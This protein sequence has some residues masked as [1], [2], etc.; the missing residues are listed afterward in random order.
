MNL[1]QSY[2]NVLILSGV[3]SPARWLSLS[4][5]TRLLP[6]GQQAR[7]EVANCGGLTD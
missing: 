1:H 3:S 5:F 4:T 7:N 6:W 2:S